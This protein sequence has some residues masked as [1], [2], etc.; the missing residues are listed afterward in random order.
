EE[1]LRYTSP[2]ELTPPRICQEDVTLSSVTIPRGELVSAVLGSANHDESRFE[3]PETLDLARDP[4]PHVSFGQGPHFCLGANL[5]RMEAQIALTTLFARFPDL[6]L[7][8]PA[9]SLRWRKLLP[10]RA[11][12]A[13]PVAGLS[14][15]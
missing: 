7:A 1:L 9:E 14:P 2:V 6:R 10:M 8:Q 4:N 3:D 11:L 12:A 13:L 15:S 5:T